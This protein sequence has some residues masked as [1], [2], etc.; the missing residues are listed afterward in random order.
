MALKFLQVDDATGKRKRVTSLFLETFF[1]GS[2][3][4]VNF[5]LT[6]GVLTATNLV[7]VYMNGV[8]LE[9][10]TD[11]TRN[12]S[13]NRIVLTAGL[14]TGNTRIRVRVWS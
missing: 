5:D 8:L 14:P 11:W 10:T 9:E 13:L 6:S 2:A 4:Q 12:T 3:A 1:T 7:D